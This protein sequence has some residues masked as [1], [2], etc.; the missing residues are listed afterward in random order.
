M[1]MVGSRSPLQSQDMQRCLR[2][3]RDPEAKAGI[4]LRKPLSYAGKA[5]ICRDTEYLI[6]LPDNG[7]IHPLSNL[8]SRG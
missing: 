6:L 4:V 3:Q 8:R 7:Q 2:A 5:F 1:V